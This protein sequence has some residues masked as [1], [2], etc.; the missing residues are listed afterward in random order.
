MSVYGALLLLYPRDFREQY[1]E[2]MALLLRDQLRH[3]PGARVWARTLLDLTLT[4]PPQHLEARMSRPISRTAVYGTLGALSLVLAI[5]A[6]T[7]VGLSVLGLLGVAVFGGLT[8][9]SWHRS[10]ALGAS[11]HADAHW[12]KYLIAGIVG[13][14]T[15]IASVAGRD[16]LAAGPWALFALGLLASVVLVAIGL[17]LLVVRG[18]TH[19]AV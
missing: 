5:T 19:N 13:A 15:C 10:R 11:G 2:D 17:S 18:R 9:L 12:W 8:W 7:T 14:T 4:V 1:A 3:E 16:E 6:A